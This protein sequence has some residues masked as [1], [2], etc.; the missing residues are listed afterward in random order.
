[1]DI[2]E[3]WEVLHKYY[4][5]NDLESMYRRKKFDGS[6]TDTNKKWEYNADLLMEKASSI[7]DTEERRK[8]YAAADEFK[9]VVREAWCQ[10]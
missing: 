1:M 6:E 10:R 9:R 4:S 3:A 7:S 2:T 8:L 5:K